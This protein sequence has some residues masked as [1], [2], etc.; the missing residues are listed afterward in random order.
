MTW[1]CDYCDTFNEGGRTCRVCGRSA[2]RR[3]RER[4]AAEK[5]RSVPRRLRD[6]GAAERRPKAG[7]KIS[8]A[9][10]RAEPVVRI[11]FI[12]LI[13]APAAAVCI[14]FIRL[15]TGEGLQSLTPALNVM[16]RQFASTLEGLGPRFRTAL[17]LIRPKAL[18]ASA[19]ARLRSLGIADPSTLYYER[20]LP[21]FGVAKGNLRSLG[22]L[23]GALAAS[24]AAAVRRLPSLLEALLRRITTR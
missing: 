5:R 11:V 14:R 17:D 6:S 3:V 12:L 16:G 4:E 1:K 22:A 10:K 23:F 19:A 8:G 18:A 21:A 2:P 24:A 9:A 15:L 13:L 7:R 20:L